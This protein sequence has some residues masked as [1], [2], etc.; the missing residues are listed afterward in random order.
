MAP[1]ANKLAELPAHI[2]T[3]VT[4]ITGFGFTVTVPVANP[5]QPSVVPVTV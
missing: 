1:A 5:V 2:V 4:V 3:G